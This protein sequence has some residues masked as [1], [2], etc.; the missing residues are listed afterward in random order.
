MLP[1]DLGSLSET[2]KNSGG[3]VNILGT[4]SKEMLEF[5]PFPLLY[6]CGT[7][8]EKQ[9]FVTGRQTDLFDTF[10]EKRQNFPVIST[11]DFKQEIKRL[12]QPHITKPLY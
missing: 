10:P 4:F 9:K 11:P 2:G 1:T 8:G 12:S 6:I 5:S 3:Q 7:V